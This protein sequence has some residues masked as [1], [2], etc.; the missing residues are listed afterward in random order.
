MGLVNELNVSENTTLFKCR[1]CDIRFFNPQ[2]I[3]NSHFYNVLSTNHWYY[4]R[5]KE[6]YKIAQKLCY[7]LN[8]ILEFGAGKGYFKEFLNPKSDYLGTELNPTDEMRLLGIVDEK[9]L[10]ARTF[11]AVVSF[12]FLEH[13]SN[14]REILEKQWSFVKDGGLLIVSI[15]S[16][17]SFLKFAF[18]SALNSPPHHLTLW[19]DK[20]FRFI[21]HNL[22]RGSSLEIIHE[23]IS[24]Y[25]FAWGNQET[26]F[27]YLRRVFLVKPT[28]LYSSRRSKLAWKI[29]SFLSRSINFRLTRRG[30]TVVA[31]FRKPP[32]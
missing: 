20:T 18:A 13:V 26:I 32:V 28:W 9:D 22:L 14:P 15:P 11:D 17:N 16:F 3:G 5:E 23:E 31:V 24:D 21:Q 1:K 6:E 8:E 2:L 7:S 12:Q 4:L 25:H 19:P 10:P 29:S 27:K 30:H